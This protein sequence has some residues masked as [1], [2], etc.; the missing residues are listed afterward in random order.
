V[1][2]ES[3]A[4]ER[5]RLRALLG[6][7][8]AGKDAAFDIDDGDAVTPATAEERILFVRKRL[9]ALEDRLGSSDAG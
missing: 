6:D 1:S 7:L 9:A 2:T 5:D 3:W 8:E 4:E